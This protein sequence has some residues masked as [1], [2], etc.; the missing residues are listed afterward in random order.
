MTTCG[1]K[2]SQTK[3]IRD[4]CL[5]THTGSKEI[6][7]DPECPIAKNTARN[8]LFYNT[9]PG[10]CK[11]SLRERQ[12]LLKLQRLRQSQESDIEKKK[13]ELKKKMSDYAELQKELYAKLNKLYAERMRMEKELIALEKFQRQQELAHVLLSS[14]E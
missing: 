7:V 14:S 4:A 8:V 11:F 3:K 13:L 12:H 9:K 10:P 5:H 1:K 6:C 2:I